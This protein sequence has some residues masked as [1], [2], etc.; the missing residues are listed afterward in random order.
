MKYLFVFIYGLSFGSFFNVVGI[1]LFQDQS[2]I[3]YR[4]YCDRCKRVLHPFE[5]IPVL[6]YCGLKGKCKKCKQPISVLYPVMECITGCLWVYSY[7][8]Y[9][10][11]NDFLFYIILWSGLIIFTVSDILYYKISN[12][13]LLLIT[14]LLLLLSPLSVVEMLIGLSV[15][16]I[17][18]TCAILYSSI[19]SIGMGDIKLMF[20]IGCILGYQPSLYIIG[21]SSIIGVIYCLIFKPKRIPFVPFIFFATSIVDLMLTFM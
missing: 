1:R 7:S 3:T 13:V 9:G 11:S 19:N 21:L 16:I 5:L 18:F 17:I 15:Q 6:S 2:L 14:P 4:S 20:L 12:K 8:I 10:L